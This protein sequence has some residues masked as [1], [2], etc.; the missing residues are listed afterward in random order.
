VQKLR[1]QEM[2]LKNYISLLK[3]LR[4]PFITAVKEKRII[5]PEKGVLHFILD[6]GF[7]LAG[8]P[9]VVGFFIFL[10]QILRKRLPLFYA[11]GCAKKNNK[12]LGF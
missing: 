10:Q 5:I 3:K 11:Y 7:A 2:S 1:I 4:A 6:D 8:V 12:I 9:Y